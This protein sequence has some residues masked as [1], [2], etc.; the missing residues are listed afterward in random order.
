MTD[1]L[2]MK[3]RFVKRFGKSV[4]ALRREWDR[5]QRWGKGFSKCKNSE[6]QVRG[7]DL[8]GSGTERKIR[9]RPQK[10]NRRQ[11]RRLV[12]NEDM[13]GKNAW[14][15]TVNEEGGVGDCDRLKKRGAGNNFAPIENEG[16]VNS[17]EF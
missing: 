4:E 10:K 8:R 9:I 11:R 5:T 3:H 14:I 7:E 16:S 17:I 1:Q 6:D 2:S 12:K 13:R 15:S